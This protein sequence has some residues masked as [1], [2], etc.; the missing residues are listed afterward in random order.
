MLGMRINHNISA[1]ITQGAL[2]SVNQ[3][4]SKSLQKL[5]TGLRINSAADDAA[6]LGISENLRTQVTGMGQALKNT[7]DTVSMLNIADG[8]LNEQANILQRMRELVVQAMNDTYTSTER[9]YMGQEFS[10]LRDELDRIAAATN[11]NGMQ[12][13][14]APETTNGNPVYNVDA[15]TNN[16]RETIDAGTVDPTDPL[17]GADDVTSGNHFNMLIGANYT[18]DDAAAYNGAVNAYSNN[19]TDMITIQFGQMDSNGLLSLDPA[20]TQAKNVFDSFTW[21]TGAGGDVED[22]RIAVGA[23]QTGE[24]TNPTTATINSK[25]KLLLGSN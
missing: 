16:P 10:S 20:Y 4:M 7:Q 23:F 17:F 12:L 15:T 5:S 8:A 19:A 6:G 18:A 3:A 25:L 13:F 21:H 9:G 1:M 22:N 2:Y 11:F 14:A 24:A